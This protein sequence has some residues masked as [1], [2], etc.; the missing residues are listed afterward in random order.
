MRVVRAQDSITQ[1]DHS[2]LLCKDNKWS[3]F[4]VNDSDLKLFGIADR[5]WAPRKDKLPKKCGQ[6]AYEWEN[7]EGTSETIDGKTV[8]RWFVA[9]DKEPKQGNW[10]AFVT[11]IPAKDL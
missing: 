2:F 6:E 3:Q 7:R 10:G 11:G 4:D 1:L 5:S 8:Y 9:C